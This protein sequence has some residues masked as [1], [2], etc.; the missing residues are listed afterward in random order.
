MSV[1]IQINSL[2]ALERLIGNDT[3]LEIEI[4]NSVVQNF[5]KQHLKDLANSE[6]MKKFSVSIQN[7]VKSSFFDEIKNGNYS[8]NTTT[9]F[10]KEFT[11]MIRQQLK[12]KASEEL[13]DIVSELVGEQK[14]YDKINAQVE[15]T[16]EWIANQL[17]QK[18]LEERVERMVEARIKE[19]FGLK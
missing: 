19:K 9:I 8:Y 2:E 10:K 1:K 6:M 13:K 11:E 15:S 5:T 7:E 4:R 3:E 17:T 18:K 16:V 14:A 12:I